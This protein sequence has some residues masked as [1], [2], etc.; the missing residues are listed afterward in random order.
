SI[1]NVYN[2]GDG[3][4]SHVDLDRFED[5]IVVI[6]LLSAC[7]MQFRPASLIN[8]ELGYSDTST[9]TNTDQVISIILRPGDVLAMSGPARYDWAH[10]I[11][12]TKI[13]IV[14]DERILRRVRVSITLRKMKENQLLNQCAD[15]S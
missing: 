15:K 14:G 1:I 10:G 4:N 12:A 8:K 2:A 9:S 13:D 3:I 11:E 6:S 5:G 7:A